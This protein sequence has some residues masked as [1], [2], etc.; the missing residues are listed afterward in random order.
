MIKC[1]LYHDSFQNFKLYNIPRAQLVI[2]DIPYNL[3]NNAFASSPEWY[4]G[5][6]N[7]NGESDKANKAFFNTDENFNLVEY[8]HFCGT[9]MRKEPKAKNEA[10]CM[11]MFCAFQQMQMLIDIAAKH[12]FKNYIPLVFIKRTSAQVLKSNMKI[13][14]ATEYGLVFYRDKL[15]K[16]RN[17]GRMIL[18]WFEFKHDGKVIQKIHAT[19]KPVNL[20]RQIIEIFTDPGDT[21]IDPVAGSAS[22]LRAAFETGRHSYGFEVYKPFYELAQEKMLSNM[23]ISLTAFEVEQEQQARVLRYMN[24]K[25]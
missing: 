9:L 17:E 14:G 10:P 20:L 21:V 13:V 16:F 3:S 24:L 1:E 8:F 7:K 22:T 12:G 4:I 6:D 23:P 19:Q 5:G 18:N 11:V 2:A 25:G 15:P